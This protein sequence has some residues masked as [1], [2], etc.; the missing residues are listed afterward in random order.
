M[1]RRG[2]VEQRCQRHI[3][4]I[5]MYLTLMAFFDIVY[6]MPLNSQQEVPRSLHLHGPSPWLTRSA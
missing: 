1:P 3:Y 2:H 5:S 6:T 4:P